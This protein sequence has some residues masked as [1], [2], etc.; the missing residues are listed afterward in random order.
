MRYICEND[1]VFEHTGKMIQR[2]DTMTIETP[3][4][5]HCRTCTYSE[6]VLDKQNIV[7]VLSV[8]L[9]DVDAKLKEGYE[10]ESLYAKTATLVKRA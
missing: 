3:I 9:E 5:P 8:P 4:C 6:Y 1:H 2:Y 7:S 10:V